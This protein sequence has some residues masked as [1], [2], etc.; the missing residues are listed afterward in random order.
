MY[1]RKDAGEEWALAQ[2]N[3]GNAYQRRI[4][5]VAA[6]NLETAWQMLFEVWGFLQK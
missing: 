4:V 5:G 1:T 3:L 2:M 6:E